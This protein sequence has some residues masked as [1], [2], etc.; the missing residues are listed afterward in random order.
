MSTTRNSKRKTT[1]R[2]R[3]ESIK[4][5]DGLASLILP[6][7]KRRTW[8]VFFNDPV[9]GKRRSVSGG[10]SRE[11]AENRAYEVLGFYVPEHLRKD[12]ACPTLAD[13]WESWLDQNQDRL[14]T[15]SVDNYKHTA[16]RL[17][18]PLG[19]VEIRELSPTRIR[20][21]DV[22][23]L[24][25]N[26]QRKVRT[27]LRHSL[28]VNERW[29]KT[30]SL[31]ELV[32]AVRLHA[33]KTSDGRNASV[34]R[35]S[36][37]PMH[38]LGQVVQSAL[39]SFAPMF[40]SPLGELE[41]HPLPQEFFDKRVASVPPQVKK[42]RKM[43]ETRSRERTLMML[44]QWAT[45][46][47][48]AAN[49]GMRIGE[50]LGLRVANLI[51]EN[52]LY[53]DVSRLEMLN[54]NM[55]TY[56]SDLDDYLPPEAAPAFL[57]YRGKIF[58]EEQA[59]QAGRGKTVV[60]APKHNS[61]RAVWV[62]P[63]MFGCPWSDITGE[64]EFQ[65]ATDKALWVLGRVTN[66]IISITTPQELWFMSQYEA[67][68]LWMNGIIP[69][70]Y[71]LRQHLMWLLRRYESIEAIDD[72]AD[73]TKAFSQLLVFPTI[74]KART[75]RDGLPNVLYEANRYKTPIPRGTNGYQSTCNLA[76]RWTN[77]IF[78]HASEITDEW[79][80]HRQ[81]LDTR[82]GFSFHALRHYAISQMLRT[83][84]ISLPMAS[85]LA[86]HSNIDFTLR[87]YGHVFDEDYLEM[88]GLAL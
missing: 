82:R 65:R 72:D 70:A 68:A 8:Q 15:R 26:Q 36:I 62:S 38:W 61:S 20:Q 57:Y 5:A 53:N 48:L 12:G 64:P 56:Y 41:F 22:S 6:S 1:T 76:A 13:C 21:I 44:R 43:L 73:R 81:G 46:V 84:N 24:S 78:D 63:V 29:L 47:V 31:D 18:D 60:G 33:H 55:D 14:N 52:T 16:K 79:P 75:G 25:I 30:F 67:T 54:L 27:I 50:L 19:E 17:L 86:G 77:F 4:V 83:P 7:A 34:P 88:R 28:S 85:K 35:G 2:A 69:V 49:S 58:V 10:H 11:E 37:P 51:D 9:T 45:M 40:D 59:S 87:R 32:S 23:D 71:L 42:N 80:V 3:R 74:S 39:L 66:P